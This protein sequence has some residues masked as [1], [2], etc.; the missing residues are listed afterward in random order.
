MDA[1][2]NVAAGKHKPCSE[3]EKKELVEMLDNLTGG[4]KG[5]WT[6]EYIR[7]DLPEGEEGNNGLPGRPCKANNHH[8]IWQ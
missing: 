7:R 3:E 8:N 5:D 6:W 1:K 4:V 2:Q